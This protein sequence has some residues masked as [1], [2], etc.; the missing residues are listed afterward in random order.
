MKNYPSKPALAAVSIVCALIL[1]ACSNST[2]TLRFITI[3]PQSATIAVTTTQQ[4]TATAFYS[5]GT[6]KDGTGLVSWASSNSAVATINASG[7]A[8]GVAPGTV[9]VTGTAAGTPGATAT[10]TVNQPFTSIAVTCSPASV[11]LGA[12][13]NC[14][15]I[16]TPGAVDVT[17]QATWSS[18][19]PTKATIPSSASTSPVVAQSVAQGSTN[20]S[21]MLNGITS[22]NFGLT[23]TAVGP[24]SLTITPSTPTV[25]VGGTVSFTAQENWSDGSTHT[26]TAGAVSWASGTTTI[27]GIL[28]NT[29]V[30]SALAVGASTIT[31]SETGLTD[32]TTT[33]TVVAG[34]SKFAYVANTGGQLQAFQVSA[35]A[36]TPLTSPLAVPLGNSLS[37]EQAVVHP[38]GNVLYVL[39]TDNNLHVFT[40]NSTTGTPT[41]VG[42]PTVA[43][44]PSNI[45]HAVIDPYGRFIYVSN[46]TDNTIFGFTIDQTNNGALTNIAG[47]GPLT[48]ANLD[49]PEDLVID[50]T[51]TYLYVTNF[52]PGDVSAYKI[53]QT[54]GAL[55]PL[56]TPTY[57]TGSGPFFETLDPSGKHLFVANSNEGTVT[58]FPLNS[59]GSL[60]TATTVTIAGASFVANA[61]TAPSGN[62]IYIMD[63]GSATGTVYAYSLS[64]G[65][66]GA[67]AIG[68]LPTGAGP[69]GM[70][71]D[72][73]GALLT[74]SNSGELPGQSTVSLYKLDPS[75][76]AL[77]ALT[78]P[79]VA[80]QDATWWTT[81]Y[82]ATK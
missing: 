3:S 6:S 9:T 73:S 7:V 81:F 66:I 16:G 26:P 75:T 74:V 71:I 39:D 41:E 20:I 72:A 52:N 63:E 11:H 43:G 28:S 18:S 25:A 36:A 21:A 76:G 13:S 15:A 33:L 79:T 46:D 29:G 69:V 78:P 19:D 48:T 59:D 23:V 60:G 80:T 14:T 68:S 45:G 4:F 61:V 56:S 82:N 31:A 44:A 2:P 24:V 47:S 67:T 64:N 53:D 50:P 57:A 27:A 1:A 17:M 34:V 65:T 55:S 70:A 32:G 62:F 49:G 54:T 22:N 58:V 10:L 37:P 42:S 40:I 51:G 38:A 5:D 12:T 30:A 8:T 35:S 77:T